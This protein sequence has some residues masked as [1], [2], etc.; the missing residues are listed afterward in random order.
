MTIYYIE[1]ALFFLVALFVS[2]NKNKLSEK[3][4]KNIFFFSV[5]FV[6][7]YVSAFRS[8]SVGTDTFQYA[9][10]ISRNATHAFDLKWILD[11]K[12]PLY[13]FLVLPFT[14]VLPPLQTYQIVSSFIFESGF[15][16]FI[17]KNSKDYLL[18]T[19]LFLMQY[20]YFQSMNIGRQS[21]AL[22][23]VAIGV[24]FVFNSKKKLAFL[25]FLLAF[26]IHTT[27]IIAFLIL[28]LGSENR[29]I[30]NITVILISIAVLLYPYLVSLFTYFFPKYSFYENGLFY[31]VGRNRKVI[32]TLFQ[33]FF[34][35][36]SLHIYKTNEPKMSIDDKREY[37]ILLEMSIIGIV[38]GFASLTSILISR[39]ELYYS[40][41]FILLV[42]I[43]IKYSTKNKSILR[44][45]TALI[46]AVP[47]LVLLHGGN[48]GIVPYSF[49]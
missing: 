2:S 9:Y 38:V 46:M 29:R 24:C 20:F 7:F 25:L 33:L 30:R 11:Q 44:W 14:K 4:K 37:Q 8:L 23:L 36:F 6:L 17:Y 39:L 21:M 47:G 18:S 26:F 48:G 32:L 15:A 5:F 27:S 3:A 19:W 22:A 40:I 28:F 1:L 10:G 16:I 49:F 35:L 31:E 45:G 12:A 43:T 41:S 34:V 42:P 13:F